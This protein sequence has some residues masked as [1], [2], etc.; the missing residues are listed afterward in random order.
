[1]TTD[2]LV[3]LGEEY[4]IRNGLDGATLTIG[5]YYDATDGLGD[6][7]DIGDITTEPGNANYARQSVAFSRADLSGNWGVDNDA[8]FSFDFTD[9]DTSSEVDAAF[10]AISFTADDTGDSGSNL[11][12][13]AN[14]ALQKART[15][16]EIST[17]DFDAGD[18]FISVD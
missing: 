7:S 8:A 12:L 15:L 14:P 3:D 11:H 4:L 16:S 17:I 1:M 18:M 6:T 9:N 10:V 5:L 2:L 13:L